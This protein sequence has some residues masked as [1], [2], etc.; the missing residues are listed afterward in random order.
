MDGIRFQLFHCFLFHFS[1]IFCLQIC[2]N[3]LNQSIHHSFFT[4]S[5]HPAIL[6][7]I[8]VRN[9]C[10]Q[11]KL[12]SGYLGRDLGHYRY[13]QPPPPITNHQSAPSAVHKNKTKFS[14]LIGPLAHWPIGPPPLYLYFLFILLFLIL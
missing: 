5:L 14:F 9:I 8:Q 4:A 2:W 7:F 1:G 12:L 3:F 11:V 13:L 6:P 10:N